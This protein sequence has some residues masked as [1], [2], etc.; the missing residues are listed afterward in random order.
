[1][2]GC[3]GRQIGNSDRIRLNISGAPPTS[4]VKHN[5]RKTEWVTTTT[6][7]MGKRPVTAAKDYSEIQTI[8]ETMDAGKVTAARGYS[9]LQT[10]TETTAGR[11]DTAATECLGQ[12]ITMTRVERKQ[13]TVRRIF[14]VTHAIT[15]PTE[16]RRDTRVRAGSKENT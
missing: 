1:M 11:K 4:R 3:R 16:R 6:E 2:P 13:G 8:T 9:G 12:G 10:I 14:L 5:W 7:A 15:A